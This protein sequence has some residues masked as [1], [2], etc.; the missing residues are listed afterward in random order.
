MVIRIQFSCIQRSLTQLNSALTKSLF[1]SILG[2]SPPFTASF[3]TV[4]A[5]LNYSPGV[6]FLVTST[7]AILQLVKAYNPQM[8]KALS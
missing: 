8:G 5:L 3:R 2:S 7:S 4:Q 6:L 1:A